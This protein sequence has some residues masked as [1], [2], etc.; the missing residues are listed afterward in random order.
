V[1]LYLA[2]FLGK[3]ALTLRWGDNDALL[4]CIFASQIVVTVHTRSVN[5][6]SHAAQ[7]SE[8]MQSGHVPPGSIFVS[9]PPE[10]LFGLCSVLVQFLN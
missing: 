6:L 2:I 10:P 4:T 8:H 7:P 9:R 3:A 5:P 1:Y